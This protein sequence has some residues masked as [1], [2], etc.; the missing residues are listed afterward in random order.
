MKLVLIGLRGS[1]KTTV[2]QLLAARLGWPFLDTDQLLQQRAGR[3]I[4]ELF[5]EG[6]ESLFRRIEADAVQDCARRDR[7]VLATGGGAILNPQSAAAL[8]ANG[9][10][11]HL[12]ASAEELWRRVNADQHSRETRPQ[13][14]TAAQSGLDEMRNLMSAR[15]A[16]YA[17][18]RDA[19]VSVEGR[20]PAGV[21]AD[22]LKLLEGA[23]GPACKAAN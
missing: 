1:G 5:D 17:A 21:C 9:L 12:S 2:G 10:V 8:K 3:T 15:A 20:A 16:I 19:E 4:R 23:G 6:G 18:V 11:V 13:L 22:I 14:V 7:V